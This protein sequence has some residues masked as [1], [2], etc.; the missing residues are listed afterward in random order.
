M[1]YLI[2]F[3]GFFMIIFTSPYIYLLMILIN[4]IM[5]GI[6]GFIKV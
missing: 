3:I 1:S 4:V 2:M 5:N 6:K